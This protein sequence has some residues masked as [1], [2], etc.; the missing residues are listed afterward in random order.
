[1]QKETNKYKGKENLNKEKKA[2]TEELRAKM[3]KSVEQTK[4]G[5]EERDRKYK[6]NH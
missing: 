6:K 2:R 4:G 1:M 3:R 5:K